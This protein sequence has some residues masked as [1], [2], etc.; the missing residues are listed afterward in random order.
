MESLD[1]ISRPQG[2]SVLCREKAVCW[3]IF[4]IGRLLSD[5][6]FGVIREQVEGNVAASGALPP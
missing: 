6:P 1:E 5:L 2:C 3:V 4:L